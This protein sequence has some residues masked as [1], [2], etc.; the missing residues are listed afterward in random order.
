[1]CVERTCPDFLTPPPDTTAI[2]FGEELERLRATPPEVVVEEVEL[3]GRGEKESFGLVPEKERMLG[4][5]LKDPQGSL[6]RLVD[7]L[8]RYH[9]LA[10][11]PYSPRIQETSKGTSSSAGKKHTENDYGITPSRPY[12]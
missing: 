12:I 11:A 9:D 2:G 8:R 10:I 4:I 3:L 7:T 6:K 5:Y 1:M